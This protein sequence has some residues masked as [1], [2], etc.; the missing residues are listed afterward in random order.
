MKLRRCT[1]LMFEPREEVSVD[2]NAML[3][4]RT[5]LSTTIAWFALAAHLEQ[6]VPV[7]AAQRELLGSVG[8]SEWT[9]AGDIRGA[10]GDWR[11]LLEAGLLIADDEQHATHRL[12]DEGMRDGHWWPLAALVHRHARWSGVNSA[13]QMRDSNMVTARDLRR[14]LGA[15]PPAVQIHPG[16]YQPLPAVDATDYDRM[17]ERRTTCRNFDAARSIACG[18]LA[19]LLQ[20]T[21]K[22]QAVVQV[23]ADTAFLKK[24]VPSGGGLHPTETYLLVQRVDGLA[25]GLYH[26]HPVR[27]ALVALPRQCG[28]PL[29]EVALAMLSGQDWF[30]NAAAHLVL[31][32]R[33]ARTNW[34]YRNH[35]KAY[36]AL[37]L[38][39]GHISQAVYMAATEC[40]LAAFVT[41]AINEVDTE[42]VF[43]LDGVTQSPIAV[44]GIGWRGDTP[45]TAEFDPNGVV[46][47]RS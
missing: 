4:G 39:V 47:A 12:R 46:W 15:P 33:F 17:L 29:H 21:V 24:N 30:A 14:Q 10:P 35:A 3:A 36:R 2:F 43:A 18:Q 8:S 42:A 5:E 40:G 6:P 34:K 9:D 41:A 32:P 37:L 22:A 28:R 31:V 44:V 7:S 1:I 27:H 20:R 23:E 25:P 13:A 16:T 45:D 26:Y 11:A 19:Q 38:D